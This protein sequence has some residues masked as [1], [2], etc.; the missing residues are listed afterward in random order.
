MKP[1]A[2]NVRDRCWIRVP[3]IA[4]AELEAKVSVMLKDQAPPGVVVEPVSTPR[5]GELNNSE[6]WLGLACN[7]TEIMLQVLTLVAS[8]YNL[9]V[10]RHADGTGGRRIGRGASPDEIA[11]ALTGNDSSGDRSK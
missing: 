2:T 3:G 10:A 8:Y 9:K 7:S 6:T 5:P 4:L 1:E 11:G